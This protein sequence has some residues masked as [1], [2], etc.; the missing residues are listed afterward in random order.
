MASPKTGS[1]NLIYSNSSLKSQRGSQS[2]NLMCLD[3]GNILNLLIRFLVS[4]NDRLL[5]PRRYSS[6]R[7]IFRVALLNSHKKKFL[8]LPE[9]FCLVKIIS[10]GPH[11]TKR[12]ILYQ[13]WIQCR[14]QSRDN[15][16][17]NSQGSLRSQLIFSYESS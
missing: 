13:R 1:H 14:F 4:H 6:L 10:Q 16:R 17:L 8:A 7:D 15:Y 5:N 9:I 3:L 12:L 11:W 2:S